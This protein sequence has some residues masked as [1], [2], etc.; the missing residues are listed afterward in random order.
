MCHCK[1]CADRLHVIIVIIAIAIPYS[2]S[3]CFIRFPFLH[4]CNPFNSP[5]F[6]CITHSDNTS[7][8]N[9]K[10]SSATSLPWRHTNTSTTHGYNAVADDLRRQPFRAEDSALVTDEEGRKGRKGQTFSDHTCPTV[11]FRQ[12][13]RYVQSLV[14]IGSEMWICIRY[15]ETNK[16]KLSALYT[17]IRYKPWRRAHWAETCSKFTFF[18]HFYTNPDDR[19][20]GPKHVACRKQDTV[21]E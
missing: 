12:T 9:A 20:T 14:Q 4:T 16:Q 11:S 5:R 21:L 2:L 8:K 6:V 19:P 15:K 3:S 1:T 7:S 10:L 13:G 17:R 18:L